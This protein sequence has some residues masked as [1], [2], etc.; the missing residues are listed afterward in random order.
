MILADLQ[1]STSDDGGYKFTIDNKNLTDGN[2]YYFVH[3]NDS[4]LGGY[5]ESIIIVTPEGDAIPDGAVIVFFS[6][7]SLVVFFFLL[8]ALLNILQDFSK[9]EVD[10]KTVAL[11]FAAYMSNL[12]LYYYL[13]Q[14]ISLDL[15]LEISYVGISA[16]G[17]THLFLPLVGLIFSWL[18]K[19]GV[20]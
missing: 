1:S 12:A 18:K 8:Y 10:L 5:S 7:L 3:C 9:L 13:T 14:F 4:A 19:G 20:E 15:M 17:I 2:V 6:L 11:G 16:F